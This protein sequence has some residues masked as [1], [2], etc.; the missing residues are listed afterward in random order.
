MWNCKDLRNQVKLLLDN[1][2]D[3]SITEEDEHRILLSGTILVYRSAC[4][5]ILQKQYDVNIVVPKA[6]T[7]LPMAIDTGDSI[8]STY[9]HRYTDGSL[10]LE[11]DSYIRYRFIDGMNLVEWMDE[12]VEPYFFSYEFYCRFGSFP[13]GERPHGLEGLIHTYQEFWH[14]KDPITTCG[15]LRYAAEETY[16][17]H[18][19]CPCNSGKKLRQCHGSAMLPYMRDKRHLEILQSDFQHLRKELTEYEQSK[20][21]NPKAKR[22]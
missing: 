16:R 3:L 14:E 21:N 18:E 15:L 1:Y 9:P 13:F 12:F 17:G 11:T 6:D 19:L 20:S 5:F 7:A 8:A 4:D 2:Q 22:S 10:C